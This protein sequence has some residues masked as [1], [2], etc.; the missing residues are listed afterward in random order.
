[1]DVKRTFEGCRTVP[2]LA[3][4]TVRGRNVHTRHKLSAKPLQECVS[5]Q[6][7]NEH[8]KLCILTLIR[9]LNTSHYLFRPQ[10]PPIL[11]NRLLTFSFS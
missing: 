2:P 3:T 1:M 9:V 4:N 10:L 8:L 5:L 11:N 6:L 7:I